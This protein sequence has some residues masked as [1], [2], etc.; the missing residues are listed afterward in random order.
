MNP[1]HLIIPH[2]LEQNAC[3]GL[4]SPAGPIRNPKRVDEGINILHK[5][6]FRT[7]QYPSTD[8]GHE[9]LAADD[10]CRTEEF[11]KMISDPDIDAM[12]ALRGGYGCMRIINEIDV[13]LVRSA[14]KLLIGFSDVSLLLNS[15]S[16]R[17][18]LVT[19]HGPVVSS[20]TRCSTG[21]IHA[22]ANLLAGKLPEYND[23]RHLKI[24]KPGHAKGI[25]RGG[26]L[27]TLAHLI[28]TPWEVQWRGS[29]LFIEDTCEPMYRIDRILTQLSQAGKLEN[30]AGLILGSFD[31]GQSMPEIEN[32][33][34]EEKIWERTLELTQD[35]DY[36]VWGDF[37][38]GH[39]RRNYPLP[40]GMPATMNSSSGT[41]LLDNPLQ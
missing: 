17:T 37:P 39:G 10:K 26:N 12:M 13:D 36:P 9:Y 5:L 18:G 35:L 27:T 19:L 11:H 34:L 28:G 41:L 8:Q 15:I 24:L 33:R 16:Q 4:F 3:I 6:G 32:K 29:L 40:V 20:L 1:D 25:L 30:L 23:T 38:S 21:S 7:I 31:A 2:K 14:A 22:F